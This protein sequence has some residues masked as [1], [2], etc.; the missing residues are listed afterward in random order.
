MSP[1]LK[2][3]I[4]KKDITNIYPQEWTNLGEKIIVTRL[5]IRTEEKVVLQQI[6]LIVLKHITQLR[7][8]AL[9][10]DELDVTSSFALLARE[11]NLTRPKLTKS[12]KHKIV[13]ARHITVEAGL[14]EDGKTFTANDCFVG[15]GKASLW[16]I[17]GYVSLRRA[18]FRKMDKTRPSN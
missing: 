15:D 6:L 18:F 1:L 10:L 5:R 13:G 9:V 2:L 8:N 4:Q 17:T 7:S 3:L 12:P 16:L 11:M 14:R